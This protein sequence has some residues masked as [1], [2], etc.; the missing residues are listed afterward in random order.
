[1]SLQGK[2]YPELTREENGLKRK[3]NPEWS[4]AGL[5]PDYRTYGQKK[6]R[7]EYKVA[8]DN[9]GDRETQGQFM[10]NLEDSLF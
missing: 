10:G 2:K 8:E 6:R 4:L 3:H 1:M 9:R 7:E 5:E